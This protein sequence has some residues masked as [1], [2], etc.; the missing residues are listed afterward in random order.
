VAGSRGIEDATKVGDPRVLVID[1]DDGPCSQRGR[2]CCGLGG[3]RTGG[4]RAAGSLPHTPANT[5]SCP[6]LATEIQASC[7]DTATGATEGTGAA[8]ATGGADVGAAT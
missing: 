8:G 4:A 2:V 5:M 1:D 3:G 7:V 6:F